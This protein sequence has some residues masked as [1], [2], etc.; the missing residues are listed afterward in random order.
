V[1]SPDP[2]GHGPRL[3]R[4]LWAMAAF[5][6]GFAILI[7]IVTHYYLL[8]AME[9]AR[10]ADVSGRRQLSAFSTLLLAVVLFVLLV[11]LAMTFRVH[12]FFF[13]RPSSPPP[14]RTPHVDA[15]AESARRVPTPPPMDD[16]DDDDEFH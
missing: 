13:P 2:H 10:G 7:L 3:K 14:P 8:P 1:F 15:W 5:L 4:T 9:A 12:R 6:L 11:G 16:E